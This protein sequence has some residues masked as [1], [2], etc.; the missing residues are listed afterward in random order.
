VRY[1]GLILAF[2]QLARRIFHSFVKKGS[3]HLVLE[4]I[5]KFFPTHEAAFAAFALFDKDE[6][7]DV[8]QEE[9]EVV[10]L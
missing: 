5:E 7:G 2:I 10:C 1:A 3:D 6:N 9:I 8:N 4:D